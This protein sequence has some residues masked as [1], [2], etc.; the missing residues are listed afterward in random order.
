MKL[1]NASGA[2]KLFRDHGL[3]KKPQKLRVKIA[4]GYFNLMLFSP[5]F[6]S[7]N[8]NWAFGSGE[9]AKE[10]RIETVIICSFG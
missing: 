8:P 2:P 1:S 5:I 4:A 10:F 9:L 6:R 7:D 3:R